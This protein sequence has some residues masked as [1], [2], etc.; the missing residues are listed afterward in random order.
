LFS[1]NSD[2]YVLVYVLSFVSE[3]HRPAGKAVHMGL[4]LYNHSKQH[5]F[6][7][8]INPIL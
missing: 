8:S 2:R 7:S 3:H 5:W 4:Y 1:I 6:H